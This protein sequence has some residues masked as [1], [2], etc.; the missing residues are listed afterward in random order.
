MEPIAV[1]VRKS[2]DW[3]LVHRC[4][5]CGTTRSNL[6]S[7]DDN[8]LNLMSIALKPLVKPPFPLNNLELLPNTRKA[9]EYG[10]TRP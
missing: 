2:G 8:I 7:G 3:A 6:I 4:R 9:P 1:W 10:E 5:K